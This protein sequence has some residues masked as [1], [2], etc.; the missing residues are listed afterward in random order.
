MY[1]YELSG[2]RMLRMQGGDLAKV[3][4]FKYLGSTVPSNRESS[5]IMAVIHSLA[6]LLGISV[7][8]YK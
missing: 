3:D 6:T 5:V 7:Q 4:V 8:F 1:A 2:S